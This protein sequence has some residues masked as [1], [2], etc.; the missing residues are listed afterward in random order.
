MT[1]FG[2]EGLGCIYWHMISKLI[3]AAQDVAWNAS[4]DHREPLIELYQDLRAGLG[5]HKSPELYGA[6]PS[7]PY[8]HTTA[9]GGARQPGLTGQ[10][11]EDVLGRLGEC[12]VHVTESRL[13]FRGGLSRFVEPVGKPTEFNYV[14]FA[15]TVASDHRARWEPRR[16]RTAASRSCFAAAT[17]PRLKLSWRRAQTTGSTDRRREPEPGDLQAHRPGLDASRSGPER[18]EPRLRLEPRQHRG[19][20]STRSTAGLTWRSITVLPYSPCAS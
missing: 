16:S 9:R 13:G 18:P 11:K 14:D 15:G 1:F 10:V 8:S 12:G 20:R 3:L 19:S 17:E 6:F 2:Y 7:D 5:T 4:D